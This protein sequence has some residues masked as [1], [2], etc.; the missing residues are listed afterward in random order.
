MSNMTKTRIGKCPAGHMAQ[1]VTDWTGQYSPC[2]EC[3]LH[4]KWS[5][6]KVIITETECDSACTVAT[7]DKCSCSCGGEK[8]GSAW[9]A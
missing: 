3:S 8:H 4:Y 7:G 2:S 9:A 6:V 5:G 1:M